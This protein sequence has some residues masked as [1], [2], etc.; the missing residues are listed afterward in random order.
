[1]ACTGTTLPFIM[2]MAYNEQE[3]SSEWSVSNF[4]VLKKL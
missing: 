1:M 3:K 4:A 2:T